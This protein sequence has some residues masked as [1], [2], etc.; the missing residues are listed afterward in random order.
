MGTTADRWIRR[1]PSASAQLRLFCFP[2]AGGSTSIYHHWSDR[3]PTAGEGRDHLEH[4]LTILAG[5]REDA[6]YQLRA[7]AAGRPCDGVVPLSRDCTPPQLPRLAMLFTGQ[8]AQYAGMDDDCTGRSCWGRC[9]TAEDCCR[10]VVEL[11]LI[12]PRGVLTP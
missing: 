8:G 7:A 12:R 2:Y 1:K 4:H 11:E 3:L 5:S 9:T 6:R 10:C